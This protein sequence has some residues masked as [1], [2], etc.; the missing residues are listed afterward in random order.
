MAAKENERIWIKTS[1]GYSG[2]Y[3]EWLKNGKE[4]PTVKVMGY[5]CDY[6]VLP[7][8]KQKDLFSGSTLNL[9]WKVKKDD[10][11]KYVV[12]SIVDVDGF[13]RHER[14]MNNTGEHTLELQVPPGEYHI[15]VMGIQ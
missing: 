7:I 6:E 5:V 14:M 10:P 11:A 9:A 4:K 8:A 3:S 1:E 2:N 13:V 15:R 12:I